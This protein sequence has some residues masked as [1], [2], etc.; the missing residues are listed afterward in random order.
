MEANRNKRKN[1]GA[2]RRLL[3]GALSDHGTDFNKNR[4]EPE[5]IAKGFFHIP[6]RMATILQFKGLVAEFEW[7]N[8]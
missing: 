4:I 2:T 1:C 8:A 3:A 6:V 7:E 5:F